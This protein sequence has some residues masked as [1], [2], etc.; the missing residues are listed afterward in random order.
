MELL[1]VVALLGLLTALLFPALVRARQQT[2]GISCMN[3]S[4]QLALAW[5]M[6]A[7]DHNGVLVLN[8]QG[9]VTRRGANPNNWVSGWLD[10]TSSSD[11]TNSALLTDPNYALLAPYTTRSPR[12]FKCPADHYR[13][14]QNPGPRVRSVSMNA[15]LGEGNKTNFANWIPA[16]FFAVRLSDIQT[17]PPALTWLFVDEH[18]DSINDGCFFVNP[19]Q[20]GAQAAWRDLPA[21]YHRG[22]AGFA[23]A[24]GHAQVKKWNDPRTLVPVRM[25]DFPGLQV[26]HSP[27]YLWIAE[28]TPRRNQ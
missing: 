28:R 9:T 10:W 6:Y 11:N 21:N 20:T 17:P 24:D 26:P 15:A 13:S 12:L 8:L 18:P 4:R 16:F 7:D 14:R 19:W 27:D 23:F 3:N 22:A 1:L 5:Q 2:Q 25:A